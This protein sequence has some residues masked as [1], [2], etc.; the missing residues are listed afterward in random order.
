[1]R[2]IAG[3]WWDFNSLL[4]APRPLSHFYLSAFLST[5]KQQGYSIF[6]IQGSLPAQNAGAATHDSV[7]TW[8]TPEE[9]NH[10]RDSSSTSPKDGSL[11]VCEQQTCELQSRAVAVVDIQTT[12]LTLSSCLQLGGRGERHSF[13]CRSVGQADD[14]ACVLTQQRCWLHV[15][16]GYWSLPSLVHLAESALLF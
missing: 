10:C 4:P 1:M 9:V 5:L 3:D 8:F 6:V 11:L 7:G 13:C 16:A 2:K 14:L 15:A 12:R